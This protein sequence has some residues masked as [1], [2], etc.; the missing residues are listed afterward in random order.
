MKELGLIA[1]RTTERLRLLT[2][3]STAANQR[4]IYDKSA[5]HRLE[6]CTSWINRAKE[7][8]VKAHIIAAR[9]TRLS[10]IPVRHQLSSVCVRSV[11]MQTLTL[12]CCRMVLGCGVVV[13]Q[14]L[15]CILSECG[16]ENGGLKKFGS[17]VACNST[18]CSNVVVIILETGCWTVCSFMDRVRYHGPLPQYSCLSADVAWQRS[19]LTYMLYLCEASR[20]VCEVAYGEYRG[21]L[22][23]THSVTFS[24]GLHCPWH[25]CTQRLDMQHLYI[26]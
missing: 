16:I 1:E 19:T 22:S 4:R 9:N 12:A 24:T 10:S 14:Q 26:L 23:G 13:Q 2:L 15:V 5:V 7:S 17:I 21:P 3:C 18:R 20:C 11:S 6:D 8:I 25:A